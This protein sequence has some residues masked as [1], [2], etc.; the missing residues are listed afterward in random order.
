[1]T[2]GGLA[3]QKLTASNALSTPAIDATSAATGI[4]AKKKM[5]LQTYSLGQELLRDL[6]NGLSRLA[7]MGY[8]DLEIFGYQEKTGQF[9][10]YNPKNTTFVSAKDYKKMADDAGLRISSSHLTPSVREYTKEN[11]EAFADMHSE[12]GVP[13]DLLR[14]LVRNEYIYGMDYDERPVADIWFDT[15]IAAA[16]EALGD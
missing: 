6:P 10:D 2:L 16:L 5:G 4:E 3:S 1:M 11:I 12:S 9:G 15:Y 7:K 14:L 13:E 8:T